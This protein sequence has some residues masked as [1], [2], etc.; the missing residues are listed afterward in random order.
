MKL[1]WKHL[2]NWEITSVKAPKEVV[3]NGKLTGYKVVVTYKYHGTV[4]EFYGIEDEHF[5]RLWTGPKDVAYRSY[6]EHLVKMKRQISRRV[7][8]RGA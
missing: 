1:D 2:F 3:E 4:E 6:K 8:A 5:Y 7:R